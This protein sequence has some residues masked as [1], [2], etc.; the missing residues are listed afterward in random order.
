MSFTRKTLNSRAPNPVD[1]AHQRHVVARVDATL[2]NRT[3]TPTLHTTPTPTPRK[4]MC[5]ISNQLIF[6]EVSYYL[7]NSN[8]PMPFG[9]RTSR[10]LP[11]TISAQRSRK[12]VSLTLPST[13]Y[14]LS[15]HNQGRWMNCTSFPATEMVFAKVHVVSESLRFFAE[16][17]TLKH[18]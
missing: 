6:H 1:P 4:N 18:I 14:R 8:F 2:L 11:T 13:L 7:F 10:Y 9:P 16:P 12:R 3:P 17:G 15:N 5:P